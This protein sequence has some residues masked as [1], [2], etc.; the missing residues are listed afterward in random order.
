MNV[1]HREIAAGGIALKARELR[2]SGRHGKSA[3][4]T[5]SRRY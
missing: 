1:A 4:I 3:T 2:Q 5:K